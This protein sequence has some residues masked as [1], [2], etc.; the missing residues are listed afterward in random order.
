MMVSSLL[1]NDR[2]V[3]I[4]AVTM[5]MV[6]SALL[7]AAIITQTSQ[8]IQLTDR[9]YTDKQALY[10]AES[11]KERGY[12]EIMNNNNFTTIGND[13]VLANVSLPGG[14]YDLTATTLSMSPKVVRMVATGRT[15]TVDRQVTVVSEV[16][17][18]NVCV[19]NNA[20]FGGSG[21]TGGVIKGNTAIHGSVHLLGEGVG[22]GNN[23]IE[24]LDLI[25]NSL[26]HNNYQGMPA[27]LLAKVP[28]M[29]TTVFGG[30]TVDTLY[31][32]LRVKN[33]AVGVSGNSEIGEANIIGNAFKET[34]DGIYIET[35]PTAIRFTGN[36]VVDGV[37]NPDRVFSDNGT[38]AL[39]DLGNLVQ[40]P[41]LDEPYTD[42]VTGISYA[43]YEAYYLSMA[44]S[45]PPITL[46]DSNAAAL[47]IQ[48]H[49]FP[50]GVTVVINGDAFSVTDGTN[51]IQYDPSSLA[52]GQAH[53]DISG[54]IHCNGNL[55]IGEKNLDISYTGRGTIYAG[56]VGSSG[57]DVDI[58]SNLMPTGIFP[59]S[60]V[61][62]LM[63]KQYMNLATGPG[64]SQLMMAG[65]FYAG[66]QVTSPKQSEMAGT[67]VCDYFDMGT[68]VPHLYQVP[69]LV[70]NLPPGLI[71]SDPI[72]VVTGFEE[73]S[74]QLD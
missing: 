2:G 65:A 20:V 4:V 22:S 36:Q 72:W 70:D 24:A 11:A 49:A 56:E 23:S 41:R 48:G 5:V 37:P 60:D 6:V 59:T 42:S 27:A 52:G 12:R 15:D 74:W 35:D 50:P 71:G 66:V 33:G 44:L 9:T 45:L 53:L 58:H 21:Q 54:M 25:G 38:E 63:A 16:I 55:V 8:D 10:F 64:D 28:A 19:W 43:T 13:G 1:S 3:A 17:E 68:N 67:F 57:G 32:K 61:L 26:V 34:M 7:G 47:A 18:E 69:A 39:Y 40:F 31:A 51:S 62:G 29:P 73:R 14:S 30:E 46:D